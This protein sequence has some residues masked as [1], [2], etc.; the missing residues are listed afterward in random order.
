MSRIGKIRGSR[1]WP[2]G[3]GLTAACAAGGLLLAG[4]PVAAAQT[5]TTCTPDA[6]GSGLS[7]AVVARSGQRIVGQTV[8]AAGCD[9]GIYIGNGIS[10]VTIA[11]DTVTGANFQGVFAQ[12]ASYVRVVDSRITGNAFKTFNAHAPALFPPPGN[13]AVAQSFAVSLFGVS[14]SVVADNEV[15]NNGRGGIGIM[16]NGRN[17]VG[18]ASPAASPFTA[19]VPSTDDA[20]V[21]NR[22]WKDYGGCS[23]VLATQNPGGT[24]SR[25]LVAHNRVSA[26][27][28]TVNEA[29]QGA[30]TPIPEHDV[31]GIVVAADAPGSSVSYVRVIGN[32]VTNSFEG[33]VIINAETPG[34]L[35]ENVVVTHNFLAGN[36]T[37]KLEAPNTAGVIVFANSAPP[38]T[39]TPP[40]PAPQS[41]PAPTAPTVPAQNVNTLIARNVITNQYFGTWS[42]GNYPPLAFRNSIRVT[43]GGTP[44]SPPPQFGYG[45]PLWSHGHRAGR[46]HRYD[47]GSHQGHHHSR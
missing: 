32:R 23:I 28:T 33:G 24:M 9:V 20:I 5:T 7:A 46:G 6:G 27:G 45:A 15:Y 40:A 11:R 13:S 38:T 37:G 26:T 3:A 43:A 2:I 44:I 35:T 39:A 47:R 41:L 10:Q 21:G 4:A 29:V 18:I 12:G 30:T 8:D 25:L 36:N 1:H 31:G 17:D 19:N 22:L 42:A 14:H 34:S 16:D